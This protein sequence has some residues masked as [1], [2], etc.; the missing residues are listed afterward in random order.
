MFAI[1]LEKPLF[2]C[3]FSFRSVLRWEVEVVGR[4]E[5]VWDM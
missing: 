1:D 2:E 3:G 4:D 5:V